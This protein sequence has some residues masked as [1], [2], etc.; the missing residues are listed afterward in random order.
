MTHCGPRRDA[1]V[2]L[3]WLDAYLDGASF[4]IQQQIVQFGW[5]TSQGDLKTDADE[6]T[7]MVAE[8]PVSAFSTR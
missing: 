3:R 6:R 2:G 5:D 4:E 1:A 8:S 7:V